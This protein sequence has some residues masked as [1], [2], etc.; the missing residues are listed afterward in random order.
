MLM[1]MLIWYF[2]NYI[3]ILCQMIC[4]DTAYHRVK[5]NKLIKEF[6]II[7][8]KKVSTFRLGSFRR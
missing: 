7:Y 6:Y 8:K 2:S 3:E 1:F 5:P 4:I